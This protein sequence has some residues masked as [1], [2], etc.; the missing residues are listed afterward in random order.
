LFKED[1]QEIDLMVNSIRND[2]NNQNSVC[3]GMALTLVANLNNK[4]LIESVAQDVL[5][6]LVH[7]NEK[8]PHTLKK[9]LACLTRIIKIKKEI[10]SSAT[11]CKYIL[12]L[13]D[14][15]NFEILL[16]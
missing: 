1:T 3:Q 15:K 9:A 12:K 8:Q 10:H 16:R 13:I 14:I 5:Q 6:F 4:G 7:S 2:L 11:W